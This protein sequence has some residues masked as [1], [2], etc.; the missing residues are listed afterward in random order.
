MIR[1]VIAIGVGV[2][3][4]SDSALADRCDQVKQAVAT[5]GYAAARKHA[6]ENYGKEAVAFGDKCL[7]G[8]GGQAPLAAEPKLETGRAN[9]RPQRFPR[10]AVLAQSR[11]PD[12]QIVTVGPWTI[13]TTYK[14]DKFDNCTMSRS[15]DEL[16]ISVVW[17]KEGQLLFVNSPKWKLDRGKAYR[18]RVV[19]GSRSVEA[20]ALAESKSVTIALADRPL[21][22][23]LRTANILEIRGEG[24]TLLVPLDGSAAAL[25]RL[26]AC[27]NKN[28]REG[29]EANPFVAPSRTP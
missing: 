14:A 27:F 22:N 29:V 11:P 19:A 16:G 1:C 5:Y 23:K 24:A 20:E 8:S 25:E 21:T 7:R 18:V 2:V 15:T 12:N 4:L 17:T 13:A 10:P 26:E 3:L 28:S 6:L 9:L